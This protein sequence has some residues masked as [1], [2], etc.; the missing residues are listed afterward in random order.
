MLATIFGAS[1]SPSELWVKANKAY[2]AGAFAEASDLY[3][4]IR[5]AGYESSE[6]YYNTGNAFFKQQDYA[7]A[8]LWYERAKRLDPSAEEINFNLNVANTK[9]SD[10]IEPLPEMF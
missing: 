8:I 4:K 7:R 1:A 5:D 6:L 9:I 10:K 2:N 3:L